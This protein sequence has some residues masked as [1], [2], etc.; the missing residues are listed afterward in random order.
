ME[1]KGY[2]SAVE[3]IQFLTC[4]FSYSLRSLFRLNASLSHTHRQIH[5]TCKGSKVEKE[6]VRERKESMC[7]S[8][9]ENKNTTLPV[10]IND[11]KD[12]STQFFSNPYFSFKSIDIE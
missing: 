9:Y 10:L 8:S 5:L 6:K 12:S 3:R 1:G 7:K 4:N 11:S 2:G